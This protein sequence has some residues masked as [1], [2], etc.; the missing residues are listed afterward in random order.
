MST[1]EQPNP[2]PRWVIA[3]RIVATCCCLLVLAI[4]IPNL[5]SVTLPN[6][7]IGY[8]WSDALAVAM[9]I[10]PLIVIFVGAIYSRVVE[11]VGWALALGLLIW[12]IA[13][14]ETMAA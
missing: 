3:A 1:L 5:G 4:A 13:A 2:I 8:G 14:Y 9:M 11:Y 7:R 12:C 10:I 6:H